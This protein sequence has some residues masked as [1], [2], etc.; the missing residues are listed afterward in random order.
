M[1]GLLR[2]EKEDAFIKM[3][4]QCRKYSPDLILLS[5]RLGLD[6]AKPYATTYLWDGA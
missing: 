2:P 1:R 3:M 4:Q 5:H 6:K